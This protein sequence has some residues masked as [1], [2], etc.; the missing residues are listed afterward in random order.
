MLLVLAPGL[1]QKETGEHIRWCVLESISIFSS[2]IF[3]WVSSRNF[4]EPITK[5]VHK[6]FFEITLEHSSTNS[7]FFQISIL[8]S[9]IEIIEFFSILRNQTTYSLYYIAYMINKIYQNYESKFYGI[10]MNHRKV[11]SSLQ[12]EIQKG[13]IQTVIKATC[14]D[15]GNSRIYHKRI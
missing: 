1:F 8:S 10:K 7:A 6:C 4:L 12:S 13:N 11:Y 14:D 3:Y 9:R 2:L 15:L 5:D